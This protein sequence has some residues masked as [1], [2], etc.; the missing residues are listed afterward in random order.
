MYEPFASLLRADAERRVDAFLSAGIVWQSGVGDPRGHTLHEFEAYLEELRALR[1]AVA[2]L[3]ELVPMQLFLLDTAPLNQVRLP[4]SGGR[5]LVL[6]LVES[7][8]L[9]PHTV[10]YFASC[11][12]SPNRSEQNGSEVT[13]ELYI[14]VI[15]R[16]HQS[17][18]PS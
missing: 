15:V 8:L 4:G 11:N 1:R 9:L 10:S 16:S 13:A 5:S 12:C 14:V 17:A 3:P 6:P 2:S 18:P 7:A